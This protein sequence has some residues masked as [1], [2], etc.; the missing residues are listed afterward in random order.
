MVPLEVLFMLIGSRRL[1]GLVM[2]LIGSVGRETNNALRQIELRAA[3][4]GVLL[5]HDLDDIRP[6]DGGVR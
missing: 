4:R 6:L 5:R 2:A 1:F 3:T